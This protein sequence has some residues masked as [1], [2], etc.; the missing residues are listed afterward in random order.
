MP[1]T[2]AEE[3]YKEKRDEVIQLLDF[4]QIELNKEKKIGWDSVGSIVKVRG[5][6]IDTLSFLSG[7]SVNEIHNTLIETKL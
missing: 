5:D 7:I 1:E 6:L 3:K 2:T 4:F